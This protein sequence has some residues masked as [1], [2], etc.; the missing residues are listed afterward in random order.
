MSDDDGGVAAVRACLRTCQDDPDLAAVGAFGE[1]VGFRIP[2]IVH[3]SVRTHS[4]PA[5]ET[6]AQTHMLAHTMP[7]PSA[8]PAD[9]VA[10]SVA[11]GW[12]LLH[13][14]AP[15]CAT[16]ETS[17][18]PTRSSAL[19][20]S[21]LQWR[22]GGHTPS[23]F[24]L[25]VCSWCWRTG[26]TCTCPAT[27]TTCWRRTRSATPSSCHRYLA[28]PPRPTATPWPPRHAYARKA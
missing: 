11:R 23:L 4:T 24:P 3:R 22:R 28:P 13:C 16:H 10:L 26:R 5:V 19:R 1:A 12:P 14:A 20:R 9:R 21:T 6:H 17:L 8:C 25:A 2:G 27:P 7:C 18:A 15:S